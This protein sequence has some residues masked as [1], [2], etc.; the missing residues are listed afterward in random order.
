LAGAFIRVR[1]RVE[2]KN[3]V[4][5]QDS[6]LGACGDRQT[7]VVTFRDLV[8]SAPNGDSVGGLELFGGFDQHGDY[9]AR[10]VPP[11]NTDFGSLDFSLELTEMFPLGIAFRHVDAGTYKTVTTS[12]GRGGAKAFIKK[13]AKHLSAENRCFRA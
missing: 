2:A 7:L 9:H 1:A 6:E 8:R 12:S 10:R 11:L 4:L 13:R 5:L 3:T